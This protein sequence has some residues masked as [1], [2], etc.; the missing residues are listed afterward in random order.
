MAITV[1]KLINYLKT[2]DPDKEVFFEVDLEND[3]PK[4]YEWGSAAFEVTGL[5]EWENVFLDFKFLET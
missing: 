3:L 4:N 5:T 1:R 2:C